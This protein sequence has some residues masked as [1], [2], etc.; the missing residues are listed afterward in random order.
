MSD[1][2]KRDRALRA[3]MPTE[4]M[5]MFSELHVP[6]SPGDRILLG[7]TG[8][9]VEVRRGWGYFVRRISDRIK[10]PVPYGEIVEATK[11]HIPPIPRSLVCEFADYSRK[12]SSVEVAASIIWNEVSNQFRLAIAETISSTDS[13]IKFHVSHLDS[14]DHLIVDCHSH[15]KHPAIFSDEDD[16]DDRNSTKFSLVVGNCD[17]ASPSLA[18]RLCLKGIF[19]PINPGIDLSPSPY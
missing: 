2:D 17:S 19:E 15:A 4:A 11:L 8:M 16:E 6:S 7:A 18:M 1:L 5:P 12:H 9:F 10:I 3:T 13:R 14:G